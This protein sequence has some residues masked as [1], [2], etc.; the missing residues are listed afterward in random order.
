MFAATIESSHHT[1]EKMA[2]F[3]EFAHVREQGVA[4]RF[5]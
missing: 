5:L 4:A 2:F 1:A 3:H